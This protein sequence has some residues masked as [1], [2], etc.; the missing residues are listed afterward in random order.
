MSL[1]VARVASVPLGIIG[2]CCLAAATVLGFMWIM[3]QSGFNGLSLLG[4]VAL[5]ALGALL[6]SLARAL[7]RLAENARARARAGIVAGK[8]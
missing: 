2:A 7:P 1:V 8:P 3:D 6:L 4:V 5:A